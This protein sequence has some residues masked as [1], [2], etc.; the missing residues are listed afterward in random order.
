MHGLQ[1][2]AAARAAAAGA[3]LARGIAHE[4]DLAAMAACAHL[5]RPVERDDERPLDAVDHEVCPVLAERRRAL[6]QRDRLAAQLLE[7]RR[8]PSSTKLCGA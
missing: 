1:L 7:L 2:N 4:G 3:L 5:E 6:S 8:P